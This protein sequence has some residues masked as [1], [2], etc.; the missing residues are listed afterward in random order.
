VLRIPLKMT[1]SGDSLPARTHPTEKV[2]ADGDESD[3]E[4]IFHD[5]RFPA[6][7]EQVN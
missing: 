3:G 7:E 2:V 6:E 4:D 5:A 1:S